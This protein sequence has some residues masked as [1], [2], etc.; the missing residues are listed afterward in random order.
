[1]TALYKHNRIC[2]NDKPWTRLCVLIRTRTLMTDSKIVTVAEKQAIQTVSKQTNSVKSHQY[3][4]T[5]ANT[6]GSTT[7]MTHI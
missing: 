6:L 5:F 1:M 4:R 3:S 7:M 2:T